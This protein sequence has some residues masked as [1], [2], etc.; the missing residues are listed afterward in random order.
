[1]SCCHKAKERSLFVYHYNQC[2]ATVVDDS[3]LSVEGQDAR[4]EKELDA[5]FRV[6]VRERQDKLSINTYNKAR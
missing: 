6:K 1:M 3:L 5:A 4:L 2:S